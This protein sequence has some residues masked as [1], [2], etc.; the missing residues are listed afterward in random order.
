MS[1]KVRIGEVVHY[2]V[3]GDTN[4]EPIAGIVTR[5][6]MQNMVDL[7]LMHAGAQLKG[8]TA[9][10]WMETERGRDRDITVHS[11]CWG[12]MPDPEPLAEKKKPLPE[13]VK[14][15]K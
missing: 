1:H 5:L 13:P 11:G 2:F 6:H 3:N 15:A 14:G 9:V 12:F 10:P 4:S 7:T 8:C